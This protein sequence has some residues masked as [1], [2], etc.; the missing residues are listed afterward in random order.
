MVVLGLYFIFFSQLNVFPGLVE[1]KRINES[2]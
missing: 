2:E 1:V